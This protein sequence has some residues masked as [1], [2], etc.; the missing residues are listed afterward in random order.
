MVM[1]T[2][3]NTTVFTGFLLYGIKATYFTDSTNTDT[4]WWAGFVYPKTRR[5]G[6]QS[7]HTNVLVDT[8][9]TVY[10]NPLVEK[11][12]AMKWINIF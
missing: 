2:T 3:K 9:E 10:E 5:G 8:G 6:S 12:D 1:L 4:I 7:V 11:A